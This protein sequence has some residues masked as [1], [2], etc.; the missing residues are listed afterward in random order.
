LGAKRKRGTETGDRGT[1]KGNREKG[2][3]EK[4]KEM[5]ILLD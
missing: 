3:Q 4:E 2:I 5:E 1:E